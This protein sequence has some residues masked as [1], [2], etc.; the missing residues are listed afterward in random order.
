MTAP[1]D[2][3]TGHWGV[4]F[5]GTGMHRRAR[6]RQEW[7]Q[8]AD[9]IATADLLRADAVG[10]RGD[11]AWCQIAVDTYSR[12]HD[13]GAYWHLRPGD[14]D[15]WHAD[16]QLVRA[17]LDA[18]IVPAGDEP[19]TILDANGWRSTFDPGHKPDPASL[20]ILVDLAQDAGVAGAPRHR[21]TLLSWVERGITRN[22]TFLVLLW[23]PDGPAQGSSAV[24]L[25]DL[26][27]P[28]DAPA[29]VIVGFLQAVAQVTNGLLNMTTEPDVALRADGRHV[30]PAA[31]PPLPEHVQGRR[32]GNPAR[33]FPPLRVGHPAPVGSD[34]PS[35][36][37]PPQPHPHR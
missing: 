20:T 18:P 29:D 34:P 6:T 17:W 21:V 28:G 11:E 4:I 1:F 8:I 23:P 19:A 3:P 36:P 13:A 24:G 10:T 15:L 26:I 37:P 12:L 27:K 7:A 9:A 30:D 32:L 5:H 2:D 35:Q 22:D 14:Q 31:P 25:R 33:V 16:E